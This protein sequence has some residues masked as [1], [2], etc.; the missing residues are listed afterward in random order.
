MTQLLIEEAYLLY[1]FSGLPAT[2]KSTLAKFLV[3]HLNAV[4]LRIDSIEQ[5]MR[6]TGITDIYDHGYQVAFQLAKDNLALGQH[7]VADSTNPVIESRVQWWHVAKKSGIPYIDIEIVCTD[8]EQHRHRVESRKTDIPNL[9]LPNWESVSQR[10]Y[11]KWSSERVIIDTANITI[12]EAQKKL[13][14]SIEPIKKN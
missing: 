8:T 1:I 9:M 13:L 14:E 12:L 3:K 2:G 7:V 4:Y 10:E 5:T 11:T 6:N